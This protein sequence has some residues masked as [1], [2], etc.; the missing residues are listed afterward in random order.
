ML[1]NFICVDVTIDGKKVGGGNGMF[2]T[3]EDTDERTCRQFL[4]AFLKDKGLGATNVALPYGST[5]LLRCVKMCDARLHGVRSASDVGIVK[6]CIVFF[7]RGRQIP[8]QPRFY[9]LPV[10]LKSMACLQRRAQLGR[11]STRARVF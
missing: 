2:I 7:K 6:D 4:F 8:L 3:I 11:G 10:E 5:V 1:T 9:H